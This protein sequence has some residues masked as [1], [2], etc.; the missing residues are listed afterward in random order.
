M[1]HSFQVTFYLYHVSKL[2]NEAQN[3]TIVIA[4]HWLEAIALAR[5]KLVI[6]DEE[7]SKICCQKVHA[8]EEQISFFQTK[9]S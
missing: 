8:T 3:R 7:I 6:T 4:N 1:N 2:A 5:V 9:E